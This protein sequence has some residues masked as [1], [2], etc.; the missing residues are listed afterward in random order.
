[1]KVRTKTKDCFVIDAWRFTARQNF[2]IPPS[3]RGEVD[4]FEVGKLRSY[5]NFQ[6]FSNH[7]THFVFSSET[8]NIHVS[9]KLDRVENH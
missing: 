5:I 8:I 6:A 4:P 3:S 2:P 1:M 9:Q 7:S